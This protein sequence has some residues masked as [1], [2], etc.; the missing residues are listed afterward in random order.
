MSEAVALRQVL[1]QRTL[2]SIG[3]CNAA[4]Q[5]T[6]LAEQANNSPKRE[7]DEFLSR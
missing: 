2:A 3:R 6:S 5:K 1:F 4:T 7:D